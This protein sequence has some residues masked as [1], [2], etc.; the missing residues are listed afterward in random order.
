MHG[1]TYDGNGHFVAVGDS[2]AIITSPDG[3]S[4]TA[5]YFPSA[6]T[7]DQ[8]MGVT[9]GSTSGFLAVSSTGT[10]VKS[11]NG[12]NWSS[13][14]NWGAF[15][16]FNGA[17][18]DSVNDRYV[19]VGFFGAIL[20][21]GGQ[22]DIVKSGTGSGTVTSNSGGISCGSACV[23]SYP[24]GTSVTLTA[25]PGSGASFAGWSGCVSATTA[26]SITVA[27]N[28]NTTCSAVFQDTTGPVNGTLSA[29]PYS[30]TQM[31]LSWS[32]FS[33][34]GSGLAVTNTYKVVRANGTA[35]AP[36]DCSGT[37][38]YQDVNTFLYDTPLLVNTQYAYRVCAYDAAGNVSTG[39]TATATTL[40]TYT[41]TTSVT[42]TGGSSGTVS[43]SSGTFDAG[44]SVSLSATPDSI[45]AFDH[46]SGDCSGT[47]SF[48]SFNISGNKSC[49]ANFIP[50]PAPVVTSNT[51][52]AGALGVATSATITAFFNVALKQSTINAT[53]FIVKDQGNNLVPGTFSTNGS[54]TTFTP[55]NL[56]SGG[57]TYSVTVT[58][59][60]QNSAGTPMTANFSWS[61]TTNP[62]LGGVATEG[63]LRLTPTSDGRIG[64]YS[65]ISGTWQQQVYAGINKGSKLQVNGTGYPMGYFGGGTPPTPVSNTQ[66]SATQTKTE[67]TTAN[68]LRITQTLTYLPGSAYYGLTWKIANESTGDMTNLR[69]LHGEDTYFLGNDHGAGFWDAPNNT[70]GV[71]RTYNSTDLRRMSLQA[72]TVP[73]A[74]DSEYYGTVYSNVT[75]GALTNTIDPLETTDNG[76]ALEWRNAT[77]TAGTAW[78][79]SAFEKFADVQV[80]S[81][82]VTAPVTVSCNAGANCDLTYTI[83]NSTI[84]TANVTLTLTPDQTG[85]S[86]STTPTTLAVASGSSQQ[87]L[88]HLT[89]PAGVADGLVG[90]LTLSANDGTATASDTAAIHVL[91]PIT[92]FTLTTAT[93]GTGA[94][95]GTVLP[96]PAQGPY[97]VGTSVLLTAASSGNSSF[98][99]WSGDCSGTTNPF[100]LTM[101][102]NKSC[103]AKFNLTPVITWSNPAAITYGTPLSATQLNA[104]AAG[105]VAGTFVYT[106][107]LGTILN[108]GTAQTLSVT[109]TPTDSANY[110]TPPAATVPISVTA[111]SQTINFG[112]APSLTHGG[113]TGNISAT[114]T[115]GLPVSLNS[116]TPGV[117][118]ISDTTVTQVSTGICIIAANQ[119]GSANYSA[120]AQATLSIPA[121][122]QV[123]TGEDG[124]TTTSTIS[125]TSGATLTIPAGTLLTDANGSPIIGTLNVTASTMSSIDALPTGSITALTPDGQ[126]LS[127]LGNAIDITISS[128]GPTAISNGSTTAKMVASVASTVK[129]IAPAMTVNLAVSS[130]F[131]APE[132]TVSYYSFDGTTWHLEGTAPVK[133]DGTVDM[134]VG[135]L[136][137]W[138]VAKF[139][140]TID[141]TAPTVTGFTVPATFT[142]V[143][144]SGTTE[145]A[146]VTGITM[147]ATDDFGVTGYLLLE[148]AVPPIATDP[149][150]AAA[151]PTTYTFNNWGNH[152]LYAY[153]KDAAG[154]ISAPMSN[155]IYIGTNS[156]V[157]GVI[158][159]APDGS[160]QKLEPTLADAQKS[161]KFAM[162]TETPTA[163]QFLHGKVAPLVNGVPQ[164]DTNR[165]ELNTGDTIV[166]LRR[167]VGL[168]QT[169][170]PAIV[171]TTKEP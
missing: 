1:V 56:L 146:T 69:F 31:F 30:S 54:Q 10:M 157:D 72:V 164:P 18:C 143:S 71:Q 98:V 86:A 102:A 121:I 90:H 139:K 155:R 123:A 57:T 154:N 74:Y 116:T 22:L 47:S 37:A 15:A 58:T 128:G 49:T 115:S 109:F 41:L 166:I 142:T 170:T 134:L 16:S 84:T 149:G 101:N 64:V 67:W 91:N 104:T 60:V 45:S 26:A 75:N 77:L 39:A 103:T 5:Q 119:Q 161:L 83:T 106:P 99:G 19:A 124:K 112:T 53:T 168:W 126:I 68:G 159:P 85:W 135:H 152:T 14:Q 95:T 167:V 24:T 9:Y 32:G 61:F 145:S 59:G 42:G 158:I 118:T 65:Y 62:E 138:A 120:A 107:P 70:I 51:P 46:W 105:N 97:A 82:S 130:K 8:Y 52:T 133:Q 122:L 4:W 50:L 88:V 23:A 147:T 28:S 87:V 3:T 156:D 165:T 80:G 27:V 125:T 136:S 148:S 162:K 114:A 108:A 44:S 55:T 144:V 79:I 48:Y 117:C 76:Y 40:Q 11:T 6:S 2:G 127:V 13:I 63:N 160:P 34:A 137:L 141:T 38:V 171:T 78:T 35:T 96:N 66:P 36:A 169:T 33:D 132:A 150:W 21:T 93:T 111:I 131:A 20:Q 89:I 25:T 43:P 113:A 110:N 7:T 92:S 100:S 29:S 153:A 129:T 163:T 17:T 140:S 94:S 151:A 73:F 12:T 81:V